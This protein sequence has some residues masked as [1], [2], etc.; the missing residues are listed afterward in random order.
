[1]YYVLTGQADFN[2]TLP[3]MVSEWNNLYNSSMQFGEFL[4]RLINNL[5]E[6]Y[7]VN[8]MPDYYTHN[9]TETLQQR[10]LHCLNRA[11]VLFFFRC[12]KTKAA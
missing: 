8:W 3:M 7:W 2:L 10:F 6:D 12:S 4:Q 9:F 5:G 1:M 11:L